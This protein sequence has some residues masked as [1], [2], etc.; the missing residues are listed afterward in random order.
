MALLAIGWYAPRLGDSL[1]RPVERI[2]ARLA[3]RKTLVILGIAVAAIVLR[4]SLLWLLPVPVP[5][6][7]DEL[8]YLLAGDTFAHGRLANPTHP[9][10]VFLETIHVNQ[11][12][13]YMSK[14]PPGQGAVLALG[15]ILGHPWIG[16]LLSMAAMCAAI[17]W[18][19]QGWFPPVWALLG[20]GLALLHLDLF[21]YWIDSYWGGAV[22]AIGGA[23][24]MGALPRIMHH[25]R[26]RDALLLG[27]G[28]AILANSRPV[29]GLLFCLPVVVVL[30][31]WW[32]RHRD[33]WRD[34][35]SNVIL[36][37]SLVLVFAA[38]FIGYY[39]WRGTGSPLLFPYVV[40][41]RAHF[42]SPPFLWQREQPSHHFVNPQ[43]EAY[44]QEQR[45]EYEDRRG[46]FARTCR[47]RTTDL[48]GFFWGPLL[49]APLLTLWWL[50]RDWR[51]RLLMAQLLLSL[52]GL[53]AV[54]AFFV[55]YAAPLTATFL[56]VAVQGMRHLRRWN[57][58]GRLVGVGLTRAIVLVAL[59]M[60]PA[61]VMK[62]MLEARHGISWTDP[63]MLERG[64]LA[65]R[66]EGTPGEHLIVV[67][68]SPTHDLHEEWVYN[69]AD[70]DHS[71]I[72]WAREI[73]G[74]DLKPLLK[75]FRG[76]TIWLLEPDRLPIQLRPYPSAAQALE[77]ST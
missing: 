28:A 38:G 74:V 50:V 42:T 61:H 64:R 45:D 58:A 14:Y 72:V 13:A 34:T 40:Y 44:S 48:L 20:A 21:T 67:S 3:R 37:V 1:F 5:I 70:I 63:K 12:P 60:V 76:R 77:P 35:L 55:H 46:H 27:L 10:W 59:A 31:G 4:L 54:S 16:V 8:S 9:M 36:P 71:K 17:A 47:I 29:E 65:A 75:Y 30:C 23:L 51:I 6:A 62:T 49:M 15:Q 18:M 52:L 69:G 41:Q 25:G 33:R 22:A 39:N 57:Y 11:V 66:L 32:F 53:L 7:H 68:Y 43:F 73:P 19:L 56:A 26:R 24:V 2:G